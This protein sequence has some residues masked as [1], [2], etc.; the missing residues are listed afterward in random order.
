MK[1]SRCAG[2][3]GMKR[4]A[5][6]TGICVAGE[7]LAGMLADVGASAAASVVLG[8]GVGGGRSLSLSA[9]GCLPSERLPCRSVAADVLA[10]S[11]VGC[12]SFLL[13]AHAPSAPLRS[14]TT[15]AD[16]RL[17]EGAARARAVDAQT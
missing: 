3:S 16:A 2:A 11:L 7:T 4:S 17:K 1:P 12:R 9:V 13:Q 10:T 5:C 15:A 8:V 14:G 6:A